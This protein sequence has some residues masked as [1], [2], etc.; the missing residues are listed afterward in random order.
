MP[1]VDNFPGELRV[2]L[3]HIYEYQKGVRNLILYT[4]P[5]K[6]KDFALTRLSNQQID[7][8]VQVVDDT[9]FNLYF[10][11]KECIEAIK[12]MTCSRPKRTLCWALCSGIISVCSVNASA[13]VSGKLLDAF[14]LR[15]S[16]DCSV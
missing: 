1:T 9:K 5:V 2:L 4:M 13:T 6:Y 8:A 10:G 3:N 12:F 14:F 16:P 7:Y 15:W 11:R